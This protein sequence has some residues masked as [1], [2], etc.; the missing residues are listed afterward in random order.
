MVCYNGFLWDNGLY[1]SIVDAEDALAKSGSSFLIYR[2]LRT[3][4]A[5][6]VPTIESS[7][8]AQRFSI[9]VERG[10][11]DGS[12]A[13]YLQSVCHDR[14]SLITEFLYSGVKLLLGRLDGG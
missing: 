5:T 14:S 3:P 9:R 2:S 8:F 10:A 4:K 12:E 13:C 6:Q 11:N 1:L 7:S